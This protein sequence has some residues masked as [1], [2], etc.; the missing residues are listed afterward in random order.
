M[1]LENIVALV[2]LARSGTTIIARC[3]GMHSRVS[4]IMEPYHTRRHQNYLETDYQKLCADF[5][6]EVPAGPKSLLIKETCSHPENIERTII[7]LE[8]AAA[9]GIHAGLV[10]VLRSPVEAFLSQVEA[11]EMLWKE[12]ADC[13]DSAESIDA[14]WRSAKR[15]LKIIRARMFSFPRRL[16]LYDRFLCEPEQELVRM[17]GLFSYGL[18]AAQ[19]APD[20][21]RWRKI[22]SLG[23][24]PKSADLRRGISAESK[25]DRRAQVSEFALR[26][27]ANANARLM[28]RIHRLLE[29]LVK[30]EVYDDEEV[31][32]QFFLAVERG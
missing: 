30:G 29:E 28:M 17:M 21:I 27:Q 1:I 18:E 3:V 8:R 32:N 2:G 19:L 9:Q 25:T 14:F 4:L 23:G 16:V 11:V 10:V 31:A 20:P 12:T 24:D 7:C 5:G 26:Y 22:A 13:K 15:A 6:V